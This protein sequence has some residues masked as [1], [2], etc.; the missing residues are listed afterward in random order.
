MSSSKAHELVAQDLKRQIERI[1]GITK[2]AKSR[3]ITDF[4]VT[5]PS[6]NRKVIM[7]GYV[8]FA[9]IESFMRLVPAFANGKAYSFE[10]KTHDAKYVEVQASQG[11]D[12]YIRVIVVDEAV[13]RTLHTI[14][15]MMKVAMQHINNVD[16]FFVKGA[17][18]G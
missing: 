15:R 6:F 2:A 12:V 3:G 1:E 8:T 10:I 14:T 18:C 16:E 11:S 9:S 4:D 17:G 7:S 13:P 5:W